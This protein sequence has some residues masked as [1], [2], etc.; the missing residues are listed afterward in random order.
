MTLL[1]YTSGTL[2]ICSS[3]HLL[4]YVC[5]KKAKVPITRELIVAR[6]LK[7]FDSEEF[8]KKMI[9]IDWNYLKL[10]NVTV[11]VQFFEK[12]IV[13]ILDSMAPVCRKVIRVNTPEW[14]TPAII[15]KIKDRNKLYSQFKKGC[16]HSLQEY[17]KLRNLITLEIQVGKKHYFLNKLNLARSAS[18][19]IWDLFN[20]ITNFRRKC[21]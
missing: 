17:R 16:L 9:G 11:N 8:S 5:Y 14:I 12:P 6:N 19:K 21:S 3:D 7:T 18:C 20:Q 4:T 10:E 1:H 15:S 13:A 2:N